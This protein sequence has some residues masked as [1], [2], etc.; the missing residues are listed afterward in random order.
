MLEILSVPLMSV[1]YF[2]CVSLLALHK[3]FHWIL[4]IMHKKLYKYFK[5][6]FSCAFTPAVWTVCVLSWSPSVELHSISIYHDLQSLPSLC[7]IPAAVY[8]VL[9]F[10]FFS[11]LLCLI[12]RS[13]TSLHPRSSPGVNYVW[14]L[15]LTS[16]RLSFSRYLSVSQLLGSFRLLTFVSSDP[17]NCQ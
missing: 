4:D 16:P 9:F 12:P 8:C 13:L 7:Y 3:N 11:A 6:Y 17:Y 1:I 15:G 10:R 5:G 2:F 14:N